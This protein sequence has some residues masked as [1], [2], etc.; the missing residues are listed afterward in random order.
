MQIKEEIRKVE[1]EN[2]DIEI[3]SNF[4]IRGKLNHFYKGKLLLEKNKELRGLNIEMLRVNKFYEA[5]ISMNE[6]DRVKIEKEVIDEI[7]QKLRGS[8]NDY[9]EHNKAENYFILRCGKKQTTNT[10]NY[11]LL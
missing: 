8:A 3:N 9:F 10:D 4:P 2:N 5:N 6:S 7:I 11:S 1:E